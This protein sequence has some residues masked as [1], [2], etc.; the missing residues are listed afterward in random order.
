L[1]A[2]YCV[3]LCAVSQGPSVHRRPGVR[4]P[5]LHGARVGS[6]LSVDFDPKAI[7]H[8]RKH[9]RAENVT[10]ELAD[11][12]TQMPEGIF[13]NIVWDAAIEHFT[14]TEIADLMSNIKKRLTPTG[15]LSVFTSTPSP[16]SRKFQ[17][18]DLRLNLLPP[19]LWPALA[20]NSMFG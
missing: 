7:N 17:F 19:K 11:I 1:A 3:D 5:G 13:D 9:F 8:A 16:T 4:S 18:D 6:I 12:R 2:A 10:Y 20:I 15:I 14:E